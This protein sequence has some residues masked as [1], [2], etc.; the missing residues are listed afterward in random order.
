MVPFLL[1]N[2]APTV[3]DIGDAVTVETRSEEK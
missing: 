1:I 3:V 2:E